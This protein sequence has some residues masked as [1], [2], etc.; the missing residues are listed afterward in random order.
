MTEL[1]VELMDAIEPEEVERVRQMMAREEVWR[2]LGYRD[3]PSKESFHL[4]FLNK[5]YRGH[6]VRERQTGREIGFF[7]IGLGKLKGRQA[8]EVDGAIADPADRGKR[9]SREAAALTLDYWLSGGHCEQCFTWFDASNHPS[10]KSA[11][12]LGLRMGPVIKE[13]RQMV[14]G[15]VDVC[16]LAVSAAEW[17]DLRAK[18]GLGPY[19]PPVGGIFPPPIDASFAANGGHVAQH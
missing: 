18:F 9:F 12:S 8:V 16:E 6:I 14:D 3:L 13:G 4:L 17:K 5:R 7:L 10:I 1:H 11:L 15:L 19:Q 2:S